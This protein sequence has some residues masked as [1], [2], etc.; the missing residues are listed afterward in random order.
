MSEDFKGMR[1]RASDGKAILGLWAEVLEH[2][3]GPIA[4]S[5][6]DEKIKKELEVGVGR[7][8]VAGDDELL[9]FL[10]FRVI[11]EIA[12]ISLLASHPKWRRQGVMKRLI[13]GV[14][15]E[16]QVVNELWLEVHREN[17]SAQAFYK[18]V[19]FR[20]VGVRKGYYGP[21]EDAILFTLNKSG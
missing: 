8:L 3:S 12:E 10:L 6:T 21:K 19:G 4:G 1:L 5:W 9:G 7:G 13:M 17:S 16:F 11:G 15:E 18:G 14:F 20:E 2:S